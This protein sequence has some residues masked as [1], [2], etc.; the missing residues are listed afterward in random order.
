MGLATGR[1]IGELSIGDDAPSV[2][3][4]KRR[5]RTPPER[6]RAAIKWSVCM[7]RLPLN[8]FRPL[9]LCWVSRVDEAT[10]R[11]WG[12]NLGT[13][14]ARAAARELPRG[15][16]RAADLPQRDKYM[17]KLKKVNSQAEYIMYLADRKA[18]A[19]KRLMLVGR[20]LGTFP[21]PAESGKNALFPFE[22]SA[23]SVRQLLIYLRSAKIFPP[24][25]LHTTKS[26]MKKRRLLSVS[27]LVGDGWTSV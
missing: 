19:F 5:G 16:K 17:M 22:L 20:A 1:S 21:L 14:E 18:T 11:D 23:W 4:C 12:A 7:F 8:R 25:L 9:T 27:A 6:P 13:I 26:K 15:S 3:C 10:P 24:F 2:G